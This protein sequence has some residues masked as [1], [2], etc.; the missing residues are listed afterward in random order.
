MIKKR[1]WLKN[2]GLYIA[3]LLTAVIASPILFWNIQHDFITYRFHSERIVPAGHS[4]SL[5]NLI[6]ELIGEFVINNPANVLLIIAALVTG[7]NKKIKSAAMSIF[8][9]TAIPLIFCLLLMAFFR[10]TLPHWSGPAYIALIPAA[11]VYLS[12]L[13]R[14]VLFPLMLRLSVI[15]YIIFL[16]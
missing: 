1:T 10:K 2:P 13:K 4:G 5:F 15:F 3:L 14:P 9:F 6:K 11:A 8:S 16:V 7:A 12:Q